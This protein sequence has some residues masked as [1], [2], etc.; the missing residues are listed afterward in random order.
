M[1]EEHLP[2]NE[3]WA[4]CCA[5][6]ANTGLKNINQGAGLTKLR[7]QKAGDLGPFDVKFNPHKEE[8]DGVPPFH[9]FIGNE[10]WFPG[11]VAIVGPAGGQMIASRT[12]GED[13]AGLIDYFQSNPPLAE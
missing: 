6:A 5:W 12:P 4:A 9:V 13:E 10:E 8:I 11:V 7:A 3:L 1:P 2:I